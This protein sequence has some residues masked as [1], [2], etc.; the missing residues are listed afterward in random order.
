MKKWQ[1]NALK[2]WF[3]INWKKD[4]FYRIYAWIKGRCNTPSDSGYLWYWWRWIKCLWTSFSEFKEDMYNTYLEHVER[5]WEI[6]TTIERIDTNWNYCISNCTWK[7]RLEQQ[8]NRRDYI[9]KDNDYITKRHNW[10]MRKH[11]R[12]WNIKKKEY[13][14]RTQ[15]E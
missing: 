2:H 15:S 10:Y 11:K 4:R 6:D 7:T 3:T 14:L 9:I 12:A 8:N 13:T 5:F 1:Q